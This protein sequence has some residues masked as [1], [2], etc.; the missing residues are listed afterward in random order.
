MA[1]AEVRRVTVAAGTTHACTIDAAHAVLIPHHLSTVGP[2]VA[3]IGPGVLKAD[4]ALRG[5][6][7][8][9]V[10]CGGGGTDCAERD[11]GDGGQSDECLLHG[12][13]PFGFG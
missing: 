4:T 7:E 8:A 10:R 12:R 1:R 6:V 13:V 11:G 2:G 9:G 3:T 5:D